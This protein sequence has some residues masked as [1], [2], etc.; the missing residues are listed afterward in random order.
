MNRTG[1]NLYPHGAYIPEEGEIE[2]NIINK[3]NGMP[4][5]DLYPGEK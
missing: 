2:M 1:K 5:G 3:I 4:K